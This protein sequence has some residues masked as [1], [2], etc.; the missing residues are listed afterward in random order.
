MNELSSTFGVPELSTWWLLRDAICTSF[1]G[2]SIWDVNCGLLTVNVTIVRT[3]CLLV[4]SF[5]FTAVIWR[6]KLHIH[7]YYLFFTGYSMQIRRQ[8]CVIAYMDDTLRRC[9]VRLPFSNILSTLLTFSCLCYK[10]EW[11]T[12]GLL[13]FPQVYYCRDNY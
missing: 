12:S 10:V 5:V 3:I 11:K 9:F 7:A 8:S 6:I 4:F 1:L 13:H 2:D